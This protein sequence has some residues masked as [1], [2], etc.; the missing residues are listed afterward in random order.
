MSLAEKFLDEFKGLD[1]LQ[2]Q[3]VIDFV[4]YLKKKNETH[5]EDMMDD[6]IADNREALEALGR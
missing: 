5:I 4:E 6:I 2:K 3:E 1:E